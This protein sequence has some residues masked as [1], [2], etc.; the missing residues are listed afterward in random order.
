[1]IP[2]T[3]LYVPGNRPDRFDKAVGTGADLVILDLEDAVPAA[4]KSGALSAVVGWLGRRKAT[5]G[6][7]LQVRVNPN[8]AHEIA[9]LRATGVAV[10]IRLPKVESSAEVAAVN[11][12]GE[13]P[14][15]VTALI[16]SARGVEHIG[17]IADAPGLT[18]VAMGE[19][20]LQSELGSTSEAVLEYAR[21][22]VLFGA[23]AAGLP[24]PM[25]SVY[26][27]IRDLEGLAADTERGRAAGFVG[28]VAV[29]PSQLD[30]IRQ[31][32]A[33]SEAEVSWA[34][35]VVDALH[36]G[37]VATLPS[38]EMVD[39]AMLPRATAILDR[40]GSLPPR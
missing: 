26:P 8:A 23:R 3:G 31:A 1:M 39:R 13:R 37:G 16:E 9:A 12:P 20:D 36:G 5:D 18:R 2:I 33:P 24:A 6:P 4:D 21:M 14:L 7:V 10:E 32:F 29:H 27:R 15:A 25:L 28:R 34:R 40:A 19:A 30:V 22:R 38:G 11:P 35:Q 17:E